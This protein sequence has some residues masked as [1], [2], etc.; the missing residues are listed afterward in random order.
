MSVRLFVR[1]PVFHTV[2]FVHQSFSAVAESGL[3]SPRWSCT[4]LWKSVTILKEMHGSDWRLRKWLAMV[5]VRH[6]CPSSS[7]VPQCVGTVQ[8]VYLHYHHCPCQ[9]V[10]VGLIYDSRN[11]RRSTIGTQPP[12]KQHAR[13]ESCSKKLLRGTFL[14]SVPCVIECGYWGLLLGMISIRCWSL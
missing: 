6:P 7:A 11:I 1:V 10:A 4:V 14:G 8:Q 13:K 9:V 3:G 12:Q 5:L 2:T